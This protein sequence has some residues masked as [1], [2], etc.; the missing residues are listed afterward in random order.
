MSKVPDAETAGDRNGIAGPQSGSLREVAFEARRQAEA[1]MILAA[2]NQHRW[3]RRLAAQALN[4]SYRT[5]L[6]KMKYCRLRNDG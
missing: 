6:Y 1:R 3:N 2:L 5:L 4:I